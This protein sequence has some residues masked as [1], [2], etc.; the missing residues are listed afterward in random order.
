[1][2]SWITNTMDSWTHY[3]DASSSCIVSIVVVIVVVVVYSILDYIY[4]DM[5]GTYRLAQIN[6]MNVFSRFVIFSSLVY[7]SAQF[8]SSTRDAIHKKLLAP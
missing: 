7:Y 8:F 2:D 1:M 3:L 6:A 5:G 4:G